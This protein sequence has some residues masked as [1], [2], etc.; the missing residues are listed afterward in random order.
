MRYPGPSFEDL[1]GCPGIYTDYPQMRLNGP[2][3][4]RQWHAVVPAKLLKD[5]KSRLG[6]EDLALP[7]FT[8]VI[9]AL[10][11]SKLVESVTVVSADPTI[12]N[13]AL[14]LNCQIVMEDQSNG[15]LPAIN[16]G[17]SS[18]KLPD[19]R[20]ILVVLG[21]LPCLDPDQVDSFVLQGSEFDSA[22][23]SD[24][25]GTGSTMWMRTHSTI[26]TPH[27][28]PRS[29]AMHRESGAIEIDDPR[30][31]GARR[32]VD[33]AVNLWD[34]I[35]IG[36]G[37]ATGKA[38]GAEAPKAYSNDQHQKIVTISQVSPP[39]GVDENGRFHRLDNTD[40]SPLIHPRIGQRIAIPPNSQ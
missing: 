9:S 32:D 3:F 24:A 34:A 19:Q 10:N 39:I 27:F 28:G 21:D 22:F 35:R 16:V 14:E 2:M 23:V 11:Q 18:L 13:L 30:L 15:I 20:N 31:I 25:E 29:R 7:F 36:V 40:L 6:R 26:P 1:V 12:C 37:K 33:T 17:I 4:N 8:D 5:A 38:L